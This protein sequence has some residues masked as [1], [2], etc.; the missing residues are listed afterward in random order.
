[1][2][3]DI[4]EE[5]KRLKIAFDGETPVFENYE[6]KFGHELVSREI[7]KDERCKVETGLLWSPF[8]L[9]NDKS[10]EKDKTFRWRISDKLGY[11]HTVTKSRTIEEY[12]FNDAHDLER[13]KQAAFC[14]DEIDEA[15][16]IVN[17][18]GRFVKNHVG[19]LKENPGLKVI[20]DFRT[21]F[22]RIIRELGLDL[23]NAKES[24]PP[25]LY[26]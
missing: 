21:L 8:P 15:Q 20:R 13:L 1:M 12:V 16:K 25:A 2:L 7:R 14:L 17:E 26:N 9:T 6:I 10:K 24:R 19:N 23:E 11:G 22:I 5:C 4:I 18:H 3:S